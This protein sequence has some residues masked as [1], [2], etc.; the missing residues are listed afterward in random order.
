[1]AGASQAEASDLDRVLADMNVS[2]S[3][4]PDDF[5]GRTH[6]AQGQIHHHCLDRVLHYSVFAQ[7]LSDS[8][9]DIA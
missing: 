7:N 9:L 3:I 1:M 6:T 2:N 4:E 8:P 5:R